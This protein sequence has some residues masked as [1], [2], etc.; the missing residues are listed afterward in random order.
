MKSCTK[1]KIPKDLAE[2]SLARSRKD[3]RQAK[4]KACDA[5]YAEAHRESKGVYLKSYYREHRD[6][7]SAYGKTAAVRNRAP[8]PRK[9]IATALRSR[10]W[11]AIKTE[12]RSG[13][14]VRD[15]GCTIPELK[16]YLESQFRPGMTWENWS[17][18]GWHVDHK[19]PLASFDLTDRKQLLEAVH[20][21]NL[22]PLWAVENLAKG[23]LADWQK[24]A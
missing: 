5:E 8:S 22:Q 19:K 18:T 24:A 17:R 13:S 7:W 16:T 2:F 10:L 11:Q 4:C 14:A 20:F 1:C 15:L 21:T 9:K 12:A 3:G 23:D 6:K